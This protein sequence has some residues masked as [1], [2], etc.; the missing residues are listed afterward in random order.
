M[1]DGEWKNPHHV[2]CI[3]C[4][5]ETAHVFCPDC[6]QAGWF[7]S[8]DISNHPLYWVCSECG[9]KWDLPGDFYDHSYRLK[10]VSLDPFSE[11]K[12]I[13]DLMLFIIAVI[14]CLYMIYWAFNEFVLSG[15]W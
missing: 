12:K 1:A 2:V 11:A 3:N 4:S 8:N 15:K 10:L 7:A 5:W 14:F 13:I 6:E 9:T